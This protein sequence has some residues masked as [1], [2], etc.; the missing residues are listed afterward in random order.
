M[1]GQ[2]AGLLLDSFKDCIWDSSLY[3]QE[4]D[5]HTTSMLTAIYILLLAPQM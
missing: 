3:L 2:P 5:L 4:T 1:M